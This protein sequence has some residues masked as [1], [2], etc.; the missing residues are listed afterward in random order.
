M[1][2][3][4]SLNHERSPRVLENRASRISPRDP[5]AGRANHVPLVRSDSYSKSKMRRRRNEDVRE[6]TQ[7]SP[8]RWRVPL[9]SKTR[10]LNVYTVAIVSSI[11][12]GDCP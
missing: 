1:D 11:V 10:I 4:S 8:S 7:S 9:S 2:A 5:S 12:I 3:F 6:S